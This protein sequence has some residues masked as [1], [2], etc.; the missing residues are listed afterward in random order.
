MQSRHRFDCTLFSRYDTLKLRHRVYRFAMGKSNSHPTTQPDRTPL[1]VTIWHG[2][3]HP[4][5]RTSMLAQL[6]LSEQ[7]EFTYRPR[8]WQSIIARRYLRNLLAQAIGIDATQLRLMVTSSGKPYLDPN[9]NPTD[10]QFSLSHSGNTLVIA[11][12]QGHRIGVDC[13]HIKARPIQAIAAKLFHPDDLD[14]LTQHPHPTTYFYQLFTAYEARVKALGSGIWHGKNLE[15]IGP[16]LSGKIL[17]CP[18]QIHPLALDTDTDVTAAAIA[19]SHCL[20]P[21][22]IQ[23]KPLAALD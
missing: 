8:R 15:P 13:E 6:P 5:Q 4:T 14:K 10:Q 9:Q 22:D 19:V 18:H 20:Q 1:C 7:H 23:L 21:I 11:L 16:Y 2:H 17:Q 3:I 12:T